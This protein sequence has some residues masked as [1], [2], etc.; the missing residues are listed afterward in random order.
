MIFFVLLLFLLLTSNNVT[1]DNTFTFSTAV[2]SK[3]ECVNKEVNKSIFSKVDSNGNEQLTYYGLMLAGAVARSA[4]A[5]AVHPLNVIKTMLQTKE[6]KMPELKW[7]ILSRGGGS[8]LIMSI[9]HG[10]VSF[11]VTEV[12]II[13][14]IRR[15]DSLLTQ[16]IKRQQ[17]KNW[18]D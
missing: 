4:A 1:G 16:F 12:G 9:P 13:F 7:S 18:I 14:L 17:R 6:G 11:A 3:V 15:S 8:Q 10:A 2:V 5:T